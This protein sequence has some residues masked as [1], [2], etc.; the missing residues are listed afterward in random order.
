MSINCRTDSRLSRR[1]EASESTSTENRSS[2]S[3]FMASRAGPDKSLPGYTADVDSLKMGQ[4][5]DVYLGK[6]KNAGKND[7]PVIL[8]IHILAEP[9]AN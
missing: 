3:E 1:A 8:M 2:S 6:K 5:A 9:A 7:P 4:I